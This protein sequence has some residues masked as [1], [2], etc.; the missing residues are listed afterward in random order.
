VL[1][2]AEATQ[3]QARG[4]AMLGESVS[5]VERKLDEAR[6]LMEAG[7]GDIAVNFDATYDE[8][9]HLLRSASCYIEAGKPLR[10][11]G[12]FDTVLKSGSLSDRD[13]GYFRARHAVA[14]AL[15]GEPDSAADEGLQAM[16]RATEKQSARTT[17]ELVRAVEAMKRWQHRPGPRELRAALTA[18]TA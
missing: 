10:A 4:L 17:K 11:A 16:R 15:S 18:S 2:Q 5:L 6:K 12:L 7:P 14:L 8:H 1:V 3:Q 13:E 9:T